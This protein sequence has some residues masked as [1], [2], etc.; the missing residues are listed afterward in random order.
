MI[1]DGNKIILGLK[2]CSFVNT[3]FAVI[4][5]KKVGIP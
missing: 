2:L 1:L 3:A 4:I 5:N